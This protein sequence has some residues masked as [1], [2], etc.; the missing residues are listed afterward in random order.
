MRKLLRPLL[1]L[2]AVM[3]LALAGC[4]G[5]NTPV[6]P[7]PTPTPGPATDAFATEYSALNGQTNSA[8]R[9]YVDVNLLDDHR[10][11]ISSEDEIRQL[12]T[13]GEGVIYFGFPNCPWC[14]NALE[15]MNAAAKR[16]GLEKI[17][18]LN[19]LDIRD[20]KSLNESGEIVVEK[21]GT[22][23]YQYLLEEL[24][25]FAPEYPNLNDSSV[26]RILVPLVVSVVDGEV[27]ASHLGT[28]DSQTDP[29]EPLTEEQ[30]QELVTLYAMTFSQLPS[31]TESAC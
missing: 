25:D 13:D 23:F 4:S 11:V 27:V 31:C 10:F 22:E 21:E 5:S 26:R 6:E 28:V 1:I 16:V 2:T 17:H 3:T 15:P 12:L 20:Q 7:S 30:F 18:Y 8:G 24:G 9:Q 19:V 14:R 29:Y